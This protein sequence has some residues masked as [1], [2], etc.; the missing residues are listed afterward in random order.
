MKILVYIFEIGGWGFTLLCMQEMNSLY[1]FWSYFLRNMFHRS[2]Y[3]E[4]RK[5]AL[6]DAEFKY[7][8]GLEC[9]FRFYRYFSQFILIR[10]KNFLKMV[11]GQLE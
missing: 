4:F 7:N 1:R 3:E 9:L 5:L 10:T 8:Y 2:M 6:E 11:L